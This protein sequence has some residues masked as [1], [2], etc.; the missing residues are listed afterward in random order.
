MTYQNIVLEHTGKVA[1]VKL[2]A[3]EVLNAL[4]QDMVAELH[5]AIVSVIASDA[6]CLLLTGEGRAF[7]A[8]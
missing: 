8:G 7:S 6:R 2:N 5:D 4:S 3:P 1:V